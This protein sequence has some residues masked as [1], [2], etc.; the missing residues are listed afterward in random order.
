VRENLIKM[1]KEGLPKDYKL[2]ALSFSG[3]GL[4][5]TATE[6]SDTDAKG[7]FVP[8]LKDI[9]T[10]NYSKVIQ[11]KTN[12]SNAKNSKED[13]DIEL[14]SI[15]TFLGLL[16]IGEI[17]AIELLF[18]LD[19]EANIYKTDEVQEIISKRDKLIA[20]KVLSF[21]G[22]AIK[23][24]QKYSVKGDRVR[25]LEEMISFLQKET[26]DLTKKE[27][28][29]LK[30]GLSK[31]NYL[32]FI[33]DKKFLSFD[34]REEGEYFVVLNRLHRTTNTYIYLIKTASFLY[35]R[36]KFPLL[37]VSVYLLRLHT[38]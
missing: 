30:I 11:V 7:V 38:L 37:F 34:V 15:Q 23:Q 27:I 12:K 33:K 26:E 18:S 5:G 17:N 19:Q 13:I 4:H 6:N 16:K 22:F 14:F 35:F 36:L 1:A 9:V 31:D 24:A 10:N 32:S 20:N 8:N 3:S 25:E 28:K 21:T 29:E 2:I